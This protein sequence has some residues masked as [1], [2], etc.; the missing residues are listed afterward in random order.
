M[1]QWDQRH[2]P[3]K[4]HRRDLNARVRRRRTCN[5]EKPYFPV[6][7]TLPSEVVGAGDHGPKWVADRD[8][9]FAEVSAAMD[10]NAG[11]S[12]VELNIRRIT[13]AG[14][15]AAVLASDSRIVIPVGEDTDS[16]SN[17]D[18]TPLDLPDYNILQLL[19][20]ERIYVR[21]LQFGTGDRMEITANL[22]PV[23]SV[24]AS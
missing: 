21:I 5:D 8:Y 3:E 19:K 20:G 18:A 10:S 7:W 13:K 12:D 17:E 14:A 16:V 24:L 6:T 1:P 11:G 4:V 22:V 2:V 9:W 15:D 23:A